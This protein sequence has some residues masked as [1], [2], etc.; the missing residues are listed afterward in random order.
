M[1][2]N[3]LATGRIFVTSGYVDLY[4]HTDGKEIPQELA[5]YVLSRGGAGLVA[6]RVVGSRMRA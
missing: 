5:M 4:G 6:R 2:R 1:D 3:A